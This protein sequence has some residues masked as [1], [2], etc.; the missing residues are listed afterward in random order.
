MSPPPQTMTESLPANTASLDPATLRS[1]PSFVAVQSATTSSA[2]RVQCAATCD[3]RT[4]PP[5]PGPIS[6]GL[7]QAVQV[8]VHAVLP[9]QH[10]L[11]GAEGRGVPP[12]AGGPH[13]A[14]GALRVERGRR[15]RPYLGDGGH[16]ARALLELGEAA[17]AGG[18]GDDGARAAEAAAERRLAPPPPQPRPLHRARS[19]PLRGGGGGGARR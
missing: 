8:R 4:R 2:T 17:E 15:I 10:N 6:S 12:E 13:V 9:G 7:H 1:N 16:G 14:R 18:G 5:T 19:P 11:L 3:A